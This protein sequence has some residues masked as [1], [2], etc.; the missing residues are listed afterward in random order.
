MIK[1]F[2][3]I[4]GYVEFC[5]KNGF[6]EGFIN[7]CFEKN[8]MLQN[9]IPNGDGF[10]AICS[11]NTYKKLHKIALKHGGIVKITKKHG[12]PFFLHPLKER[13]GF[14]IGAV[15]FIFIF[16]LLGSFVWNI[17]I[18]GCDRVSKETIEAYLENNNL[19][20]GV[21]WGSINTSSLAWDMMSDFDDIAWAHINKIGTTA[22]VEINET[23][24]KPDTANEMKLK[25]IKAQRKEITVSVLRSQSKMKVK[26]VKRY[27]V[28]HFFALN[29]PLY[30]NDK[31]GDFE[32]ESSKYLTIKNKQLPLGITTLE[33]KQFDSVKYDL[34]DDEL[35]NLAK[36]KLAVYTENQL[37]EYEIVNMDIKYTMDE[38]K[39]TVTGAYVVKI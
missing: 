3:L 10:C 2:R 14:L 12:L 35:L 4:F 32:L 29:I 33:R 13:T 8:I 22:V 18:K 21:M 25:G 19:K 27:Y 6:S 20:K 24:Q 23:R 1:I 34:N 7:E 39:C 16:S 5:F 9:I 38:T 17:E 26:N 37:G 11:I 31:A 30:L 28:L 15:M 36:K